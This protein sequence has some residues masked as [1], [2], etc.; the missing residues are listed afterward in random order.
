MGQVLIVEDDPATGKLLAELMRRRGF[1]PSVLSE[2]KLAHSWARQHHPELIVLDLM[3]PDIDGFSVCEELKLDRETNLIPIVM[4]TPLD[5]PKHRVHGFKVGANCYLAK[6][7]ASKQLDCAICA[8]REWRQRLEECGARGE[9]QFH[10]QSDTEYLDA[11]NK[12]LSSLFLHSGLTEVQAKQLT[13]AVREMGS[14][15]IE[16]GHQKQ[17]N[18]LVAVT[19]RM[20][21]DKVTVLI[22]DTG[23]GF[24]RTNLS[25]AASPDDPMSHLLVREEL[26][27]R[28]GGFGILMANGLVDELEYNECGN[29]VRLVKYIK[30][31]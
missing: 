8:A 29:E 12:L 15:A 22:Q 25:H 27:I 31:Q 13:M 1:Q 16:W 5:D 14:N 26:G 6:P 23:P 28:D 7:F 4:V 18:R 3:L 2:G 20:E 19:Y 11:L 21:A 24:D 9:V 17:V 30:R 10:L